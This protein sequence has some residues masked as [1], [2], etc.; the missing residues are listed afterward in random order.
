MRAADGD[1]EYFSVP[2]LFALLLRKA[3]VILA[4]ALVAAMI[5]AAILLSIPSTYTATA[6]IQLLRSGGA[7]LEENRAG[8]SRPLF[9]ADIVGE[10]AVLSSS[11]VL[12]RVV[13]ELGLT[14]YDEFQPKPGLVSRVM[15]IIRAT[16]SGVERG[17]P[18]PRG[19]A[20]GA[21]SSALTVRQV[22]LSSLLEVSVASRNPGRAADITDS[23]VQNYIALEIENRRLERLDTVDWLR[24][25]LEE[26]LR[27]IDVAEV[28]VTSVLAEIAA[29]GLPDEAV[30][31]RQI[32]D[33]TA[34]RDAV[35]LDNAAP[36]AR[37][38]GEIEDR[39]AELEQALL[40][41]N[42]LTS[43]LNARE[44]RLVTLQQVHQAF[45]TRL[46]ETRESS[47]FAEVSARV[48]T[49]AWAPTVPSAPRR[50]LL[51]L[52]TFVMAAAVG[53]AVVLLIDLRRDG[54]KTARRVAALTGLPHLATLPSARSR[55]RADIARAQEEIRG[56]HLLLVEQLSAH[57]QADDRRGGGVVMIA[58][59]LPGEGAD[60]VA[61]CLAAQSAR[62]ARTVLLR[63]GAA[64]ATPD[65]TAGYPVLG[66]A[67]AAE[68]AGG[69]LTEAGAAAIISGLRA[70]HDVVIIQ[71]PPVLRSVDAAMLA[72]H[73]DAFVLAV[74]WGDTPKG[75]VCEALERL[76]LLG[77]RPD[78]FVLTNVPL[79]VAASFGYPGQAIATRRIAGDAS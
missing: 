63:P 45:L 40:R 64:P 31:T 69:A 17:K 70:R 18:D 55:A 21:L 26:L 57:G 2:G 51:T 13:D 37:S 46:T 10:A 79:A 35:R 8:G 50:S 14:R 28:A 15:A 62:S 44:R 6:Q 9:D 24:G 23:I 39:I 29:S 33:L 36:G 72:Q 42:D 27:Q 65:A 32:A 3:P 75:A 7:F 53:S 67:E 16:L 25:R 60:H 66:L 78:G 71:T 38:S 43:E 30:I 1:A 52:L 61:A 22:G 49:P 5:A 47:S 54:F 12:G 58:S 11:R 20:T 68:A 56:L 74:A 19:L 41:K 59:A 73:A 34:Q 48:V 77:V 76:A 4:A